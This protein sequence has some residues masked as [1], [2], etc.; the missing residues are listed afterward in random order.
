ML[1]NTLEHLAFRLA[2]LTAVIYA[3]EKTRIIQQILG[4]NQGDVELA[5]KTSAILSGSEFLSDQ[6]LS[7]VSGTKVPALY[8][9]I[10]QLGIVFVTNALVLYV[11]DKLK[12]DE[13]IVKS[14]SS[15]ES[16]SLQIAVLFIIV[17]EIS[18]KAIQMYLSRY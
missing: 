9:Q 7:I 6:L 12:I 8:K 3:G 5:L 11:L 10:S 16:R 18:V 2:G 17:Q 15:A 13:M 4:S 1:L 14:N